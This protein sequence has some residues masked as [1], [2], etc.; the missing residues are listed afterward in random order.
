MRSKKTHGRNAIAK[1]SYNRRVLDH[2]I[3]VF[4]GDVSSTLP[5][6]YVYVCIVSLLVKHSMQNF[7]TLLHRV[8]FL[9][10]ISMNR[11]CICTTTTKT[12]IYNLFEGISKQKPPPLSAVLFTTSH[13]TTVQSKVSTIDVVVVVLLSLLLLLMHNTFRVTNFHFG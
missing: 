3:Q 6:L 7:P 8:L 9:G 4:Y 12:K 1:I 10:L 2:S 5:K 11:S 13:K